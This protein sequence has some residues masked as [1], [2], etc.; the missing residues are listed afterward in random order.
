LFQQAGQAGKIAADLF[1]KGKN[2]APPPRTWWA[3]VCQWLIPARAGAKLMSN[4]A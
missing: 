1:R 4:A 3:R 2:A